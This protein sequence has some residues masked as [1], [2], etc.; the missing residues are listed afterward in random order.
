MYCTSDSSCRMHSHIITCLGPSHMHV[1]LNQQSD[2]R[3]IDS[4]SVTHHD[5]WLELFSPT[6]TGGLVIRCFAGCVSIDCM[7]TNMLPS[8]I[9]SPRRRVRLHRSASSVQPTES[10]TLTDVRVRCMFAHLQRRVFNE[11]QTARQTMHQPHL[12]S[13]RSQ[14][15]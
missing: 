5:E 6:S 7:Y 9:P 15:F 8:I 3:N 14:C 11:R 1:T 12:V 13:L 10:Q 4:S 2:M